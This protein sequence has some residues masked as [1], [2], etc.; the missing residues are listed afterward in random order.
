MKEIP[1]AEE[2]INISPSNMRPSQMMIKFAK[3]HVE[4]CKKELAELVDKRL[5]NE[6]EIKAFLIDGSSIL[7]AYP[8]TN[9]K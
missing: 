2:F 7:K 1:T 6:S 9:I 4:A 3:L 8:L 5:E